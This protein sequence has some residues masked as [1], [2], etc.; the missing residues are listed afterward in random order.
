ML[1]LS[2]LSARHNY[3]KSLGI[4]MTAILTLSILLINIVNVDR[5]F[6][7]AYV[8]RGLIII[9]M[10]SLGANVGL[11]G[12]ICFL[13]KQAKNERNLVEKLY[14]QC[15]YDVLSGIKNRNAFTRLAQ[16]IEKEEARVSVMV[17]DID[18]LKIINDTIGH[19][20]GD[21]IVRK[22]AEILKASVCMD[23]QLFRIGGDEYII[24]FKKILTE[25]KLWKLK[26]LIKERIAGYNV[27]PSSIPLSMSIGFTT[28]S[29]ENQ[30]FWSVVKQADAAMYQE[31]RS[32]KEKVYR[33]LRASLIE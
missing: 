12:W 7:E 14:Q 10:L 9:M 5:V 28:A 18:G 22:A 17:C 20:A 2:N 13:C 24:V 25:E 19:L 11:F 21:T 3:R 15:D 6:S 31:K 30:Q 8:I 23:A 4:V 29:T 26:N 16:Q 32:C 1:F 27:Q 33:N